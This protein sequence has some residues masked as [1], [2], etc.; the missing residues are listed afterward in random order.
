MRPPSPPALRP[1]LRAYNLRTEPWL[2]VI[3][4]DGTISTRIEGAFSVNELKQALDKV[5]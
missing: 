3:N 2:F 4:S 1:Q 5:H